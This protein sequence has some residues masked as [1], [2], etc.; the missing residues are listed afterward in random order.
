VN[1]QANVFLMLVLL[2]TRAFCDSQALQFYMQRFSRADLSAKAEI[3][4][5]AASDAAMKESMGQLYEYALQFALDNSAVLKNDPDMIKIIAIAV[6]GLKDT[7]R[8]ENLEILWQ[9]FSEYTDSSTEADILLAM[10]RLGKGDPQII[11]NVNNYL[12]EINSRFVSGESVNYAIVS[13]GIAAIMELGDSSSYPVLFSIMCAGY[14][15]VIDMEAQGA[16]DFIPGN[17]LRFLLDAIEKNPPVEKFAAFKAGINSGRLSMSERGQVAE[18]A[19][20]QAL[21]FYGGEDDADISAMRYA[22]A[23]ALVPLRWTRANAL[24][25]RHYYRVQTDYQHGNISKERF[26]EA[27]E[28]LGA[29]GNSDAAL[30]LGLQLGLINARAE[31]TGDIDE[32]IILAIVNALGL[33]GDKAAFD[34]LLYVS[35]LSYSDDIQAAAKEAINRLKW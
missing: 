19:F 18:L 10:G 13:A 15:E 5:H 2:C 33:I 11:S 25:I 27:I 3:F 23:Q 20:E 35:N 17:F 30:A 28:L 26:I 32:D 9:L 1:K 16:L 8:S 21:T 6:N 7:D 14:P 34:H 22:A 12:L 29:V 24:A 31:R 4:E